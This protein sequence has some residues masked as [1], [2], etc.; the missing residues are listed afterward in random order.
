MG[1]GSVRKFAA[2]LLAVAV[3]FSLPLWP[4]GDGQGIGAVYGASQIE[5]TATGTSSA[6]QRESNVSLSFKVKNVGKEDFTFDSSRLVFDDKSGLTVTGSSGTVTLA[7]GQ[8]DTVIF[9]VTVAKNAKTGSRYHQLV[10]SKG[11][12]DVYTGRSRSF[13]IYEYIATPSQSG[14]SYI[15]T[16]EIT[17][18]IS[19]DAG[20]TPG[21]DNTITFEIFNKGNVMIRDAQLQLT[22][23]TGMTVYKDSNTIPLGYLSTSARKSTFVTIYVDEDMESGMHPI[24]VSVKGFNYQTGDAALQERTF[25]VPVI[26][27]DDEDAVK[28]T[29]LLISNIQAPQ[30]VQ[31]SAPFTLQFDVTNSGATAAKNLRVSVELPPEILNKTQN[32]FIETSLAAGETKKYYVTLFADDD[33]AEKNYALKIMAELLDDKD[34]GALSQYAGVYVE[35]DEESGDGVKTPQLMVSNYSYGGN[36]VQAG[37][38]FYLNLTLLNTSDKKLNNIKVTLGADG[39]TMVPVDSSNSFFVSSVAAKAT[40]NQGMRFSVNPQAEQ[41]T[42][43]LSVSMSY[44]DGDGNSYSAEDTISISVTQKT[45]LVVDDVVPPYECYVGMPGSTSVDFYNMGKTVL[46][47]LRINAEGNFDIM[48]SNSYYAGNMASGASDSYSFTFIPREIGPMEGTITFS[49]EDTTGAQQI[50]ETPFV[51][52]VMEMPVWEEEPWEEDVPQEKQIPWSIIIAAVVVLGIAGL[53]IGRKIRKK[54][55]NQ[56]VE[57]DYEDLEI[58]GENGNGG[59]S[60]GGADGK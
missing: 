40:V 9:Y 22:L 47:N 39:G 2:V 11:G 43:A 45:R 5:V 51:F 58:A 28:A 55:M 8:E 37:S 16:M 46:S 32:S 7:P 50:V 23:P 33:V 21:H 25:Y 54:K 10:L 59:G 14:G 34:G 57:M 4:G 3:F 17:P 12:E 6:I 13:T 24:S 41:K 38:E 1:K 26:G 35:Q 48:E 31:G 56:S 27:K 60:G 36:S 49:Y 30:T 19:P 18:T 53:I 42:S 15:A 44:E 20:F 29:D 52:E